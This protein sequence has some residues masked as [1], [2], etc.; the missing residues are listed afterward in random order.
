MMFPGRPPAEAFTAARS[1]GF[2]AVEYLF[3]YG[4]PVAGIKAGLDDTGIR[5]ILPVLE[6]SRAA[7]TAVR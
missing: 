4:A 5:M 6:C 1:L 3:P 2:E 7:R